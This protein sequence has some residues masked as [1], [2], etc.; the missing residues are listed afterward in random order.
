MTYGAELRIEPLDPLEVEL[1][2]LDGRDL[3][4]PDEA[5]LLGRRE[6]RE[7]HPGDRIRAASQIQSKVSCRN[8]T[9]K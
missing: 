2:E 5:S 1:D 4:L 6:E 9:R 8:G 3:A 7:L